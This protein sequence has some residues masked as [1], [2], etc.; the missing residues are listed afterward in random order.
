MC[1]DESSKYASQ[2]RLIKRLFLKI[3]NVHLKMFDNKLGNSSQSKISQY[4]KTYNNIYHFVSYV[5][6]ITKTT[7]LP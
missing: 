4:I 5:G 1:T 6:K 7:K 2:T 3:K